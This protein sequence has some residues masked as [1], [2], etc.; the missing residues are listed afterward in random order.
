MKSIPF[1]ELKSRWQRCQSMLQEYIPE[2]EGLL[3]FSRLNIY[4]FTGTM[5]NGLFWLPVEGQPMLLCRRGLERAKLET[6]LEHIFPFRSYGDILQI[7]EDLG[8]SIPSTIA[9]EMN[10]L[11]WALG[12]SL[13]KHLSKLHFLAGDRIIAMGRAKKS[14]W[15]LEK[16]RFAGS[17]HSKCM[18]KLLPSLLRV[19][20]TE[21]EVAK[22]FW[23]VFF[24]E[25]HQGLLR[26]QNYGEEIFLGHIAA[27]DSANYSSVF[28]GPV[29]LHGAH[30]AIP[31]MG[32]GMKTWQ[33]GEPL[34]CDTGFM[35][36]GYQTDKTQV[37]W[38]GN[39]ASIPDRVR[40]AHDF[41]I[42][43]QNWISENLKPGALPGELAAHC[44]SWAESSGWSEGFMALGG[45]KVQFIGHGIGLAIDEYPVIA[46][47]VDLPIE[48]GMVLAVEPKIGIPGVGM[49]G[50]EN[51]FEVTDKGGISLTGEEYEILCI[52]N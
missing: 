52:T 28:N 43:I 29:G 10:G 46:K 20:M 36:E 50:V 37:Y 33:A 8:F 40:A 17:K 4:Y 44:F 51:T 2:A 34:I 5:G 18:Q 6:P 42:K 35:F 9:A 48:Q 12:Q 47:G 3:I 16:M 24:A 25:G 19:N 1:N 41:C 15:E 7:L 45:N 14:E 27:G 11:S 22:I 21:K 13:T 26:M 32:S 39:P 23:E 30:P 38:A 31:H 49:V